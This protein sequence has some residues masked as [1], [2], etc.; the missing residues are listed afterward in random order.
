MSRTQR[1]Q[2]LREG[3]GWSR[4]EMARQLGVVPSTVWRLESGE[5]RESGPVAKLLDLLE[6]EGATPPAAFAGRRI[7][8]LLR[9]GRL[10]HDSFA[11]HSGRSGGPRNRRRR[12]T[13]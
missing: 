6:G 1:T 13:P 10:T 5:L 12:R 9:P 4:L 7:I 8:R 11:W 3:K 2:R